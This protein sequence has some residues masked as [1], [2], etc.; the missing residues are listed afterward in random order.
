M[1]TLKKAASREYFMANRDEFNGGKIECYPWGGEYRP[2]TEFRLAYDDNFIYVN[3]RTFED[4]PKMTVT[5]R[6]GPVWCDS[7]ME[8][9][10]TPASD[11]DHGYFNFEMNSYP[12]LLLH[13]GLVPG[14]ENRHE[15][16]WPME[17]F[18]LERKNGEIDGR[19]YWELYLSVPFELFK[20]YVPTF[21]AKS[22]TK[23]R[24]NLF[25]CGDETPIPHFGCYFPI[26]AADIPEPAFHVPKYF[27][28]LIF[29]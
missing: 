10:C 14:D 3:L 5:K 27:G 16:D 15:V 8:F 25:K 20:H 26:D 24:A 28:E 4:D 12:S 13:Y 11:L 29:E 1:I 23:I 6:N 9:F 7:C 2:E 22:G 18:S 19:K 21:E 17:A